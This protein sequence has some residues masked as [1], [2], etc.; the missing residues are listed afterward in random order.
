MQISQNRNP[1]LRGNFAPVQHEH[2][3]KMQGSVPKDINGVYLRNGPN[4]KVM[5]QS[6]RVHLFDGDGMVHGVKIKDGELFY[7][8]SYI[9]TERLKTEVAAEEASV[10]RIGETFTRAGMFKVVL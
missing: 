7:A 1:Y 8:N 5:T 2:R 6:N 9:Q 3:Y 10:F 4:T